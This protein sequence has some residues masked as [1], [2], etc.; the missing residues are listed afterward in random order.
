MT[1]ATLKVL[2]ALLEDPERRLYGLQICKAAGLPSG[3]IYPILAR[4]EQAGWLVSEW[5]T[6]DPV[7]AGRPRRRHYRLTGLGERSASEAMEE[8]RRSVLPKGP[9]T[10]RL[11]EPG[12]AP[13]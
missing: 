3:S 12:G 7:K 5:E 2:G 13:A 9:A 11:P 4:L 1:I 6:V 8:V 10:P